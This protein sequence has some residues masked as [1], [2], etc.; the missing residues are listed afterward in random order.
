VTHIETK[1]F[2]NG[3]VSWDSIGISTAGLYQM[4]FHAGGTQSEVTFNLTSTVATIEV[5]P[6]SRPATLHILQ[7]PGNAAPVRFPCPMLVQGCAHVADWESRSQ[8]YSSRNMSGHDM[9]LLQR[10]PVLQLRDASGNPVIG[11]RGSF[12]VRSDGGH[13]SSQVG[14]VDK[15]SFYAGGAQVELPGIFFTTLKVP[16]R[17][18]SLHLLF[19]SS[20]CSLLS[21]VSTDVRSSAL[22]LSGSSV[23]IVANIPPGNFNPTVAIAGE[24]FNLTAT[25]VASDGGIAHGF[26]GIVVLEPPLSSRLPSGQLS[27][28]QSGP[29]IGR[30]RNGVATFENLVIRPVGT[31]DILVAGF[32]VGYFVPQFRSASLRVSSLIGPGKRVS[33]VNEP[34]A[35]TGGQAFASQPILQVV[36]RAGNPATPNMATTITAMLQ[37]APGSSSGS[38]RGTLLGTTSVPCDVNTGRCTFNDLAVDKTGRYVL[39]FTSSSASSSDGVQTTGVLSAEFAV[40]VGAIATVMSVQVPEL[41]TGGLHFAIQPVAAVTD[42]GGNWIY[43]TSDK[44]GACL[45][46]GARLFAHLARCTHGLLCS[47]LW[48]VREAVSTTADFSNFMCEL[49][50]ATSV[51]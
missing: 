38:S 41:S 27:F 28:L 23:G 51:P 12:E 26:Q 44:V 32:P 4:R 24:P 1:V 7:Q 42:S 40:H 45:S 6:S 20:C 34:N 39:A 35:S 8:R 31:L 15:M 47:C 19:R 30:A 48:V 29:L 13:A 25:A 2:V 49:I 46:S 17:E 37:P 10:T 5:L 11:F 16:A 9:F 50:W 22:H 14:M 43:S 36:D 18:D 3:Q 33:V 21:E